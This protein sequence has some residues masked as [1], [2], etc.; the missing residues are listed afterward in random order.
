MTQPID[1]AA[2]QAEVQ[3]LAAAND[4][5]IAS[6]AQ[7]G[8]NVDSGMFVNQRVILLAEQLLGPLEG[9]NPSPARLA[10][11]LACQRRFAEM[12]DQIQAQVRKA[13]LLQGVQLNGHP[14]GRP[15]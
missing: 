14:A 10:Y 15:A 3:R 8:L 7:R 5:T 9:D 11:E 13:T 1:P 2:V 6:L 4:A 12:L